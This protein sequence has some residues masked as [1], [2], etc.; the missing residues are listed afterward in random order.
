MKTL[1]GKITYLLLKNGFEGVVWQ[2]SFYDHIVRLAEGLENLVIYV[3]ENPV[4]KGIVDHYEDYQ[5]SW[6]RFGIKG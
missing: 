4:R 1:K 5:W 6:D 2:R 3:L